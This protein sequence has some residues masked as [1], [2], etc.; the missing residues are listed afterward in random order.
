MKVLSVK[1]MRELDKRTIE[2]LGISG[3]ILMEN[4][5][6]MTAKKI[7]EHFGCSIQNG[8]VIIVAGRGNNGGDGFVVARHLHNMGKRVKILLI[9]QRKE[10]SGDAEV[11]LKILE[12]LGFP[13]IYADGRIEVIEKNLLENKD[14]KILVDAIFGTGLDSE[15]KGIYREVIELINSLNVIRVSVDIPSGLSGDKGTPLGVCVNA[16]LTVTFGLPKMGLL[17]YPGREFVGNLEVVDIGFPKEFIEE[18]EPSGYLLDEEFIRSL[19]KLRKKN[20]HKG[21]FGHMLAICGYIGKTGAACLTAIGGIRA[22]AGLVTIAVPESIAGFVDARVLESLTF[23]L[24]EEDGFIAMDTPTIEKALSEKTAVV[25]G[26]GIGVTDN[27]VE[28]VSYIVESSKIPVLIDAD[29]INSLAKNLD[30]LKRKKAPI[31]LTPHPGEMARLISSTPQEVQKNR[32]EIACDFAKEFGV[33]VVLKGAGT[34][35]S[36]PE[37]KVYFNPTGNPG[38]ASGGMGDVLT[39]LIGGFLAQGYEPWKASSLGI[40]IHGRAGDMASEKMGKWGFGAEDLADF[41]PSVIS[42]ILE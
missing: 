3:L 36:S 30:V 29:G 24:K 8:E 39:G 27:T 2:E 23:P 31:I 32:L 37:G 5:G 13:I 35:I 16:H 14:I 19:I 7:M 12:K 6:R 42:E 26:P 9:P 40:Y 21:S 10:I 20:T 15:V 34:I 11:N 38:M 22:G 33:Y 1:E 4:A 17:T 25:I 18:I 28:V 41:I